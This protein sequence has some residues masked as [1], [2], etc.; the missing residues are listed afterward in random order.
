M[1]VSYVS[2][3][4]DLSMSEF[5]RLTQGVP[6]NLLQRNRRFVHFVDRQRNLFGLLLLKKLWRQQHGEHLN[7]ELLRTTEFGRPYLP[8]PN[9][10][11][12]ISHAGNYVIGVLASN[13]QVGIDIEKRRPVDF[14]DFTRTM[15]QLQWDEITLS[16]EPEATFFHY[17]CIK[18]S[19][20]KVDGR[21]LSLP[22]TEILFANEQ[23]TCSDKMWYV[24]SFRLDS[25]HFGCLASNQQIPEFS[26]TEVNWRELV[27][28]KS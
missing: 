12:N 26:L 4:N 3:D 20:I 15:N 23:V 28:L 10:D 25:E 27:N 11:F 19:V 1:I 8:Q 14:N 16:D 17:W 9:V 13:A 2:I 7:L 18:E 6:E 21:G 24:K 22:L 5:N